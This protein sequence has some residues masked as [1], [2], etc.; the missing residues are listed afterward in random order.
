M[1]MGGDAAAREGWRIAVSMLLK[2]YGKSEAAA[3]ASQL[4]LCDTNTVELLAAAQAAGLGCVTSTSA[5]RLFD[6]V[7]SLLGIRRESTF[8]GEAATALQY[9]ACRRDVPFAAVWRGDASSVMPCLED[10]TRDVI[11][12][13]DHA[14]LVDRLIQGRIAGEPVEKLAYLFHEALAEGIKTT[15]ET[16]RKRTGLTTVVLS[17]GCFCNRLLLHLAQERLKNA[18]FRVLTHHRIPANDGGI[19]LGQAIY[20][21]RRLQDAGH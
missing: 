18:G 7:S 9:T 20:A 13:L 12:T 5:G 21:M 8:E 4:G 2:Q 19:A 17:G 14:P 1:Q 6:A 16:I 15:C 3:L 10:A 11:V